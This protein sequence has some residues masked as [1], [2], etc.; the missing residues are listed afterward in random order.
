[1]NAATRSSWRS[2]ELGP[3]AARI[4]ITVTM[5]LVGRLAGAGPAWAGVITPESGGS[6][7]ADSIE[8]LYKIVLIIATV[9]FCAVAG[10]LVFFLV[11]YRARP[12]HVASQIRGNTRLELAWTGAAALIL[13]VLA[14]LT[15]SSLHGIVTPAASGDDA[16]AIFATVDQP[17]APGDHA[18]HIKVTGRQFVWRFD[19]PNG[20][21]SY[22]ELQ[23]PIDTTVIVDI[24]SLDVNHSWWVPKLGGK[25]DAIPGYVNHTWFK[26]TKPG[27]FTGQC[28]EL[29]GQ[30]HA[31]MIATVRAVPA[32]A[33]ENWVA[34]Q[35]QLIAQAGTAD[36]L[37]HAKLNSQ[38]GAG[39]VEN[40]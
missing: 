19:Y 27:V 18:L 5:L 35:K 39:Q 22:E 4:T 6:S 36:A 34:T 26:I 20:A 40:P 33:W 29:C 31:Q 17:P 3:L 25:F 11:R 38:V 14:A 1:M 7:N 16:G 23:V 12:G 28:A 2:R 10:A 9:I 8:G 30:H 24:Y 15:F 21:Y 32:A 13:V 37:A